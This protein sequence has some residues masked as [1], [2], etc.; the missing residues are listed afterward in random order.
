MTPLGFGLIGGGKHGARYAQHLARDLPDSRLVGLA[1]RDFT[2]ARE[3]AATFGCRAYADYRDLIADPDVDAVVVVVPPTLHG[4]IV[5]AAAAHAR[6]VLL[7]KPA[8]TNL[9]EGRR[10]LDVVRAAGIPLMVAQTLRYNSVVRCLLAARERLGPIHALCL[11]QRFEPSRLGWIDDPVVAGGGVMLHTGIHCFDLLRLLSGLEA[12][13]VSCTMG[14]VHTTRTED[15]FSAVVRLGGG[16]LI[17]TVA[18]SRATA[19]RCGAIEIAGEHGQLVADH[20]FNT[21]AFVRGTVSTPLPVA[22]AVP[23]VLE[24]LRDFVAALRAGRPMPI[25]LEDG[26]RAV[27][28]VDAC[29]RAA[30]SGCAEPVDALE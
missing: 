3:Q 4:P 30:R 25:P 2:A 7:E 8:A 14:R 16:R 1:R 28:I 27:A 20:V 29:Y 15:N 10:M 13:Q 9:A 26:L 17:G 5:E 19:G 23:T 22:P 21:V 11:S 18:G 24:V 12:D 6:P